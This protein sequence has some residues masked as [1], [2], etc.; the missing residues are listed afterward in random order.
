M[1]TTIKGIYDNGKIILTEEPPVKTK[2]DVI[3]TFLPT[4]ESKAT[5]GKQKIFL[6][7]LEGKIKLADDFNEP[8]DD[9][10]EYM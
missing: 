1:L 9:L 8:L 10:K 7:L 6:G 5:P 2:A 4:E 3:V